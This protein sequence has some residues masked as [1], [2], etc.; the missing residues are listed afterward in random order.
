MTRKHLKIIILALFPF[1]II[2]ITTIIAFAA[3]DQAVA[4][5]SIKETE[6]ESEQD[7]PQH[8]EDIAQKHFNN[9][10]T[11]NNDKQILPE[12]KLREL[13]GHINKEY[14]IRED[15]LRFIEKEIPVENEKAKHAAIRYVKNS[16]FIY[17]HANQK[18]ALKENSKQMITLECLSKIIP[19]KY[20][21]LTR[22]IDKLMRDTK[23]RDSHL[24][25]I[26]KRYFGWKVLNNGGLS[27]KQID[28]LC[29]SGNF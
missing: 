3:K 17:Y 8:I 29:E 23:E 15:I 27:T 25:D 12:E 10:E 9:S 19:D 2:S 14:G 16:N 26:D 7:F 11:A 4:A 5:P 1:I 24:W 13:E 21:A 20:I 28:E 6:T 22:Q 18:E